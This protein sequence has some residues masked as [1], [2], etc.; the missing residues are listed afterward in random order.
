MKTFPNLKLKIAHLTTVHA[1]IDNRILYKE[2]MTLAQGQ[3]DVVL[4]VP[5]GNDQV[6]RGVRIR[7]I[8]MPKGRLERMLWTTWKVFK[9]AL[10]EEADLYHFHDPELIPAGVLLKFL[11]K[12]VVYDVHE[13][14]PMDI[15]AKAY[16][17]SVLKSP[18]AR[19]AALIERIAAILLD[20][21]VA[22][23][24]GIAKRFPSSKTVTVQN[25][26]DPSELETAT[27]RPYDGR[28]LVMTYVGHITA[29]RGI[30]QLVQ[31]MGLLPDS[32]QAKLVLAGK[33]WPEELE[34]EV[35]EMVGWRRIEFVGWQSREGI[36]QILASARIGWVVL[37]PTAAYLESYPCKL[38]E[39][40][41][42]GVPVLASDFPL[43]RDIINLAGCGLVVDPLDPQAMALAAQWL[44]DHPK[45][46]A[47]MGERGQLAVKSFYNWTHQSQN[48]F[49]L[50]EKLIQPQPELQSLL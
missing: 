11:G 16:V 15:I 5:S 27:R 13:D 34:D 36:A 22:A 38:F 10:S 39:Y 21:I 14:V 45:E 32:L 6:I 37:N 1:S 28:P 25:F 12:R 18:I 29:T 47:A 43:W 23:T 50:Y 19:A 20:G 3:Y 48:L 40:M 44:L 24:P 17:P 35:R 30:K 31:A 9:A 42:A 41:A 2:C 4:I 49:R 7:A 33:F 46:A 8:P 26:P